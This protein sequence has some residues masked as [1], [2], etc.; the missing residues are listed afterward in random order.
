MAMAM[1]M[2]MIKL[3][4]IIST[5]CLRNDELFLQDDELEPGITNGEKHAEGTESG[6]APKVITNYIWFGGDN[7][8]YDNGNGIGYDNDNGDDNDDDV[9][10]GWKI[11]TGDPERRS[12]F[13]REG[14]GRVVRGKLSHDFLYDSNADND[15]DDDDD[16]AINFDCKSNNYDDNDNIVGESDNDDGDYDDNIND[17]HYRRLLK[18]WQIISAGWRIGTGNHKC[19]KACRSD[20]VRCGTQGN[21]KLHLI[22]WW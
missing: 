19:W 6:V 21:I 17:N 9:F 13:S 18:K 8:N 2:M 11:R 3:M 7:T 12:T 14:V 20:R 1:A 22:W 15:D 16:H 5:G 10:A 4:I